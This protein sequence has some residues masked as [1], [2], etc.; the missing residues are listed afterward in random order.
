MRG[1]KKS[2]ETDKMISYKFAA[3]GIEQTASKRKVF[4]TI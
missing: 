1:L 4:C 2:E 3:F